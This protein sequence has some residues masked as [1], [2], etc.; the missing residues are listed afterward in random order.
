MVTLHFDLVLEVDFKRKVFSGE[1]SLKMEV[2]K[3]TET[4]QLDVWDLKV[5][6]VSESGQVLNFEI[7]NP[8]PVL[9][10]LLKVKLPQTKRAGDLLHLKIAYETSPTGIAFSW[11]TPAQTQTHVLPYLYTQCEPIYCR[12]IAPLQDTPSVKS[13]YSLQVKAP[14]EFSVFVSAYE[15]EKIQSE[16]FVVHRFHQPNLTQS[17]LLAIVIGN[18]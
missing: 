10:Q 14:K 13:T 4:V 7:L 6:S 15:V 8:N 11:L 16:G 18:L 1:N 3:D 9:G 2:L 17:Y 12:S 5:A